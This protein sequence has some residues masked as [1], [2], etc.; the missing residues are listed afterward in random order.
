[1]LHAD[2]M[3]AEAADATLTGALAAR[4]DARC[5]EMGMIEGG[6]FCGAIRY[7]I[8]GG[9]MPARAC[10]CSRCRKAFNGAS[11][12]YA[13][14]R[15]DSTFNWLK[16]EER[17]TRHIG[18]HG[19]GLAFCSVCG[20]TLC[21][22]LDGRVHGVTLGCVDGDPQVWRSKCIFLSVPRLRGTISAVTPLAM[23]VLRQPPRKAPH[24]I[25]VRVDRAS[26]D[27]PR[28]SLSMTPDLILLIAGASVAGFVQGLSG[29]A[30]GMVA[31]SFW[32]WGLDPHVA[33]VM[34]VFG[35]LTGQLVATFPVRRGLRLATLLPFLA[36]GLLGIPLGVSV[37]P[38][39]DPLLFKLFF[40][41]M[42]VIICPVMLFSQN[43]P[44]VTRGARIGDGL[45]GVGG[46]IMSGIGGFAGV[47]PTLWCTVRGLGKEHQRAVIQNFNLAILAITMTTYLASGIVTRAM[48]SMLP[49][50]A[51][52][53]LIP[54]LIGAR[55]YIG[56]SETAFRRII[57]AC[58]V[59]R[60]SPCWP[61]RYRRFFHDNV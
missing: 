24:D 18:S 19:W 7:R 51:A 39:L 4:S 16:G 17:L 3:V 34:A 46:G 58:S 1:M 59:F 11:S 50:V 26:I 28:Y 61:L 8:G 40:G 12:A 48:A 31:M 52:A 25:Y 57:L 32:V 42:L 55:I 37:L 9:L 44:R 20:S 47:L 38:H 43:L 21:G 45:A 6:C 54:N 10:H 56:L 36:G 14:L 15:E 35:G 30:F 49:I 53:L 13:P 29:F 2:A 5:Q 22:I 23:T 41:L 60:A 27:K 33:S